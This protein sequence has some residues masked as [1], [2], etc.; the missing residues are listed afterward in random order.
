MNDWLD[1]KGFPRMDDTAL[2]L[3]QTSACTQQESASS[4][5]LAQ[6]IVAFLQWAMW[7]WQQERREVV[8]VGKRKR[9]APAKLPLE[10]LWLALLVG[11]IRHAKHLSS[12]W[13]SLCL[14]PTGSFPAVQLTYE[15][16]RKR[17]LAAGT[18]P[19]QQ[20]FASLSV[21]LANWAQAKQ[22]SA[23]SVAGFATQVVAL[24]ET[25]LDAVRR[26]TAELRDLPKGDAHLLVGKLAGLFDLRLQRWVRLQLRADVLAGCS[27]GVLTLLEGLPIGSLILADLGYFS[28]PWFDYL[29]GQG[30][31]W[32][33]RLKERATYQLKEVLAYD[34]Q[35][36]LLDAIVWLGKYRADR[37]GHAVRLIL[38]CS[39]GRQ[40]GY[41]TN[42][43]DPQRLSMQDIAQLYVRRWDIELAFKLLKCELGLQIW[44]AARPELVMIQL[45][46]ALILAQ[47]LHALQLQVALQ[48]E[49]EPF[50]VSLHVMVDLLGCLPADPTPVLDRLIEQ[51][52]LLG[53]IR[54][55]TRTRV[56]VPE[57]EPHMLCPAPLL[58]ELTRPARYA[59]R[60][61]HPRTVPFV[62]RF[63]TQLLI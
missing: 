50:D 7:Q 56:V 4:P 62:S 42:V 19:L 46:I 59:Q 51:G 3:V 10:Q 15:A 21:A 45:W 22:P 61:G 30:Y 16:V 9:G 29:T 18:Q 31:F 37:C 60:N 5:S 28:F 35:Q 24:D 41:L 26:L 55:S 13:R 43:L 14:E 20:L 44:W 58:H 49:V 8:P 11:T 57:L 52:R 23:L 36:G 33:S 48:A 34:D 6:Q 1:Q 63:L 53:L 40:Y 2:T 54:P 39:G 25:T 27:I 47:I 17:L 38:F 12:I 32:V